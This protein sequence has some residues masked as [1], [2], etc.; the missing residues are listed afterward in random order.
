MVLFVVA[1]TLL[2]SGSDDMNIVLWRWDQN[3]PYIVF[4]SGHRSNVFQVSNTPRTIAIITSKCNKPTTTV[5]QI[6]W[7]HR[8]LTIYVA[9][10]SGKA[11]LNIAVAS[12]TRSDHVI[13]KSVVLCHVKQ[14]TPEHPS[15]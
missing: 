6:D 12:D 8:S 3:K 15:R 2:A 11:R 13:K 4:E 1:G 7:E 10:C 5:R 9:P 14:F